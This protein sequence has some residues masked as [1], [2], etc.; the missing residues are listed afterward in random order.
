[1]KRRSL[2]R[3]SR[4]VRERATLCISRNNG[5]GCLGSDSGGVVFGKVYSVP[6]GGVEL[7]EY[8]PWVRAD[9]TLMSVG[10]LEISESALNNRDDDRLF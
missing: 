10:E 1:M 2:R 8:L 3:W 7:R 9:S 4:A 5:E 6:S